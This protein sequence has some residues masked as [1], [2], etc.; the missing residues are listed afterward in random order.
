MFAG[1]VL[2][3]DRLLMP[4]KPLR[5][6]LKALSEIVSRRLGEGEREMTNPSLCLELAMERK[7]FAK[8]VKLP[9]WQA[10]IAALGLNPGPLKGRIM[11]LRKVA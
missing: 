9:E 4:A 3:E 7:N 5:G 1:V 2:I 8:L 10:W 11:G 6:K